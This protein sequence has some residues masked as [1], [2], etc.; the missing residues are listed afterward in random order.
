MGKGPE[1]VKII[2]GSSY[3]K[4]TRVCEIYIRGPLMGTFLLSLLMGMGPKSMKIIFG[5]PYG[6]LFIWSPYGKGTRICE[7]YIKGPLMGRD[8]GPESVKFIL[9]VPLWEGIW[10]PSLS[11]SHLIFNLKNI[12]KGAVPP[13][14]PRFYDKKKPTTLHPAPDSQPSTL[15]PAPSPLPS[16][17]YIYKNARASLAF[18]SSQLSKKLKKCLTI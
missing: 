3:G 1:S 13:P 8:M 4:G 15:N 17:Y 18:D 14:L 2:F 9:R 11:M 12:R 5:S 6:D 10:D 7:I 16:I